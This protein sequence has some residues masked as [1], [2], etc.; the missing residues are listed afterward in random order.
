MIHSKQSD[1][2]E[3][4]PSTVQEFYGPLEI[5][6]RSDLGKP[7]PVAREGLQAIGWRLVLR[8]LSNRR[9]QVLRR[10]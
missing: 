10:P 8:K 7:E 1:L 4:L 9:S 2:Q 3:T 5:G 6:Q